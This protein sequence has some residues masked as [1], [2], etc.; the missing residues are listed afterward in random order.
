MTLTMR[1]AQLE[2]SSEA[3][4]KQAQGASEQARKLMEENEQL[5][6]GGAV[7]KNPEDENSE[8]NLGALVEMLEDDL[9]GMSRRLEAKERDLS[10]LKEQSE[11]LHKEY[12]EI[13]QQNE[14][15]EKK[16]NIL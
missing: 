11:N 13:L 8:E 12:D 10:T 7:K 3:A 4:M 6:K 1:Q 16:V 5:L 15:L 2:A 9:K 14:R